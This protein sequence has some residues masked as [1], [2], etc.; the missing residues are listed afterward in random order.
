M[1]IRTYMNIKNLVDK[2][3]KKYDL[4]DPFEISLAEN[5]IILEEDLGDI[6][7]Y[8]HTYKRQRFIHLNKKCSFKL[9]KLICAHELGYLLIHPREDIHV[10]TDSSLEPKDDFERYAKVFVDHLLI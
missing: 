7:G 8:S 10:V 4:R 6:Y 3:V 1:L 9:K 5:I 2:L